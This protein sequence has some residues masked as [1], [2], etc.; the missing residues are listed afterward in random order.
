MTDYTLLGLL[1]GVGMASAIVLLIAAW[2][3]WLPQKS[4]H[5]TTRTD[6]FSQ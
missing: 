5:S 3:G 6:R 4:T 2:N 1:L